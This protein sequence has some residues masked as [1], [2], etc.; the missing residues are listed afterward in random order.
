MD[1]VEEKKTHWAL[2][3][4]SVRLSERRLV[5]GLSWISPAKQAPL[6]ITAIKKGT[7][8]MNE[9]EKKEKELNNLYQIKEEFEQRPKMYKPPL[10]KKRQRCTHYRG[11]SGK[12]RVF[13][14]E[15]RLLYA[16]KHLS[17]ELRGLTICGQ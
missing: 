11:R 3:S 1:R 9:K 10:P 4:L 5:E 14:E 12:V 13:T 6:T 15:E 17:E 16:L 7:K 8:D 2:F